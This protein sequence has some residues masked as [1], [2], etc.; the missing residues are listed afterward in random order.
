MVLVWGSNVMGEQLTTKVFCQ[1]V[2]LSFDARYKFF[3][4]CMIEL[5]SRALLRCGAET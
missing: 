1:P 2:W 5:P 3:C 4:N